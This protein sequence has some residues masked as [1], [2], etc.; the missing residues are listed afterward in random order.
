MGREYPKGYD[1]FR[2]RAK[3]AFVKNKSVT[4]PETVQSLIARG[5]FV[6]RELEA[7][8]YLRKYRTMKHRYYDDSAGST[9][10]VDN[11]ERSADK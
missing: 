8:Y 10:Y 3:A 1:Y 4:D 11:I 7:M 6:L 5:E 2:T 9:T